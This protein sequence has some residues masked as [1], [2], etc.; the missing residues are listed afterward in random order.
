MRWTVS[1][2]DAGD[3]SGEL[4]VELP[5]DLLEAAGWAMGDTLEL[6]PDPMVCSVIHMKKAVQCEVC[7]SSTA[8]TGHGVLQARWNDG[9]H[10]EMRL[11]KSC[12]ALAMATL[13]KEC[14][15]HQLRDDEGL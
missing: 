1:C 4:I 12:F 9:A 8:H 10:D 5:D 14:E 6:E 2:R 11:C 13:R 15:D 3:G 7:G